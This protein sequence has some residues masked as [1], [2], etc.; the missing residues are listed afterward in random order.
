MI[1]QEADKINK[2]LGEMI[3][4]HGRGEI[5]N[6]ITS[7]VVKNDLDEMGNHKIADEVRLGDW[8]FLDCTCEDCKKKRVEI[9]KRLWEEYLKRSQHFDGSPVYT[10][11]EWLDNNDS[12][13]LREEK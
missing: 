4:F 10:F 2:F 13:F 12:E 7:L 5:S 6:F 11:T 1:S 9:T 8:C 3:A